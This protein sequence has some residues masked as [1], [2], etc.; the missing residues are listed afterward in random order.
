[1]PWA[2]L[3]IGAGLPAAVAPAML[4]ADGLPGGVQIIAGSFE[5]RTGHPLRRDARNTRRELPGPA[6]GLALTAAARLSSKQFAIMAN[7]SCKSGG[8]A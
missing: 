8:L 6:D 3:A 5:D 2:C 1:M 4:G 7:A